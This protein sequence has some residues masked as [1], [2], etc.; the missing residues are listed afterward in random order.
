MTD[1]DPSP[2]RSLLERHWA[3]LTMI[4]LAL[5]A[6][7]AVVVTTNRVTTSEHE[8]RESNV[9]S[10]FR[11][12]ELTRIEISAKDKR[13][14]LER[15]PAP[16]GGEGSW[17]LIEPLREEAETYAVEKLLGTLEFARVVRR[18]RAEDVDRA[19]FGLDTPVRSLDIRMG[20]IHYQLAIGKEAA[21]PAG[22]R[23]LEVRAEGAPGSGVVLVGRDL[24]QELSVDLAD[25]RG[26]QLVPYFSSDASRILLDGPG[27]RRVLTAMPHGRWRF[28][29]MYGNLRLNR[30]L[31]DSVLVQF[32][33]LKADS[34]LALPEAEKH[35]GAEPLRLELTPKEKGKPKGILDVGG[36]CPKN[37]VDVIA[38]RRAPDPVAACVPK[39][40]LGPLSLPAE[41]LADRAVSSGRS[42]EIESVSLR[43]GDKTLLL[44][45]KESGF[46]LEK[47][48]AGDVSL[49]AGNAFVARLAEATGNWVPDADPKALGLAPAAGEVRF[50]VVVADAG[51]LE[52]V[53][54]L[55]RAGADGVLHVRRKQDGAVLALT[56]DVARAFVPSA[57][58]L[59]SP[60]VLQLSATQ[61]SSVEIAGAAPHQKFVRHAGGSFE[62][63]EPKGYEHDAALCADIAEQLANLDA[64]RWVADEDDGSFGFDKPLAK[65]SFSAGEDAARH[66]LL[67]G[68]LTP[69]GVYAKLAG[70]PG[71]F[72]ASRRVLQVVSQWAI[73][74]GVFMLDAETTSG[75]ILEGSGQ[76]LNLVEQ[77]G[78]FV[79]AEGST[80][81]A[82]SLRR[83]SETLASL[84]AE[85]AVHLGAARPSEGFDK[86][87]LRVTARLRD[88]G[89]RTLTIGA[90]DTWQ[91]AAVYYAR[92]SG[93][94]ATFAIARSKVNE[95][96]GAL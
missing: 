17:N 28:E 83:V 40:V 30:V 14:V 5:A 50:K 6:L 24:F 20:T 48:V 60:N 47:P 46:R 92:V 36:S 78:S 54:E 70:E 95:L 18:I 3:N 67:L 23:Y 51:M 42:D 59:R 76:K 65:V 55:G 93:V 69:G 39:S 13:I 79:G 19:A 7:I 25:L 35:L 89:Q 22:A 86:P 85:G 49:E 44:N 62:L 16:D 2:Q 26:R 66:E 94:Q 1:P 31:L 9:L 45:R 4:V 61:I 43:V 68:A 15:T 74:R 82:S 71:V 88:G 64:Q 73:N 53:V 8:A 91:D 80:Q 90:A 27:G 58:L 77:S 41:R 81:S 96:T 37:E 75:I 29:G 63:I 11:E 84:R 72:V 10:A 87:T 56:R 12:S 33:R 52:E 38:I 34:F 57:V 21:Q 32:A